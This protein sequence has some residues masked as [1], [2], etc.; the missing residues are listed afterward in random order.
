MLC[1]IGFYTIIL[2]DSSSTLMAQHQGRFGVLCLAQVAMVQMATKFT[3]RGNALAK[4][5]V[6]E[7]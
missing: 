1:L 3:Q 2:L 6:T 7:I 5:T 4:F